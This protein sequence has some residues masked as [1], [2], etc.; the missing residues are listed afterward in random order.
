MPEK[1]ETSVTEGVAVLG[2]ETPESIAGV[3]STVRFSDMG[4]KSSC[5]RQMITSSV[6]SSYWYPSHRESAFETSIVEQAYLIDSLIESG[7]ERSDRLLGQR[8]VQRVE[9]RGYLEMTEGA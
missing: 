4:L 9:S 8:R 5:S 2:V 6:V 1:P 3:S 7:E